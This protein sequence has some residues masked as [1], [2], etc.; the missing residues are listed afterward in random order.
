VVRANNY[1][2]Y[3]IVITNEMVTPVLTGHFT[4]SG[5]FGNDITA[6]VADEPNYINWINGHQAQVFWT[7]QGRETTGSFEL[8]LRP[9][10]YYFALNNRFSLL[11]EKQVFLEVDLNYKK[12]ETESDAATE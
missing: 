3:R 4:A 9:G 5:G 7:T 2:F 6:V 11:M 8:C 12:M 10:A 1:A